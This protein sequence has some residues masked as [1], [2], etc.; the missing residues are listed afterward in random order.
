MTVRE[1]TTIFNICVGLFNIVLGL[2]IELSLIGACFFILTKIPNSA[3]SIPTNVLLPFVLFAGLIVAM[4][5]SIKCVTWAVKK[6]DLADK[7]DPK[8]VK[9]YIKEEF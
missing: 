3:D 1:R 5:I 2:V 8:A 6:F 9:R 4:M 7:L